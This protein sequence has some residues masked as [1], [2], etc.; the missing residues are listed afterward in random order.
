MKEKISSMLKYFFETSPGTDMNYYIPLIIIISGL[1]LG[2][3]IFYFIY[4]KKKKTDF[5]FKKIFK[6]SSKFLFTLGIILLLLTMVRFEGIMYLSMRVWLYI[7]LLF[8]LIFAY[9]FLKNLFLVYPKEKELSKK[10]VSK[11]DENIKT[12]STK[13]RK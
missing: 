7:T 9:S 3:I 4:K 12:Y 6:N 2:S 11:T 10:P 5:A 8:V 1:L 13:K